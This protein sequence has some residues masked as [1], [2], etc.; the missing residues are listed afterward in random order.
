MSAPD[1]GSPSSRRRWLVPLLV[2]SVAVNLVIVGA[3]FSEQ[4]WPDHG[5]RKGSHRSADLMPRSF[6]GA[7]DDVRREELVEVFR[8]RK[9]EWREE[10]RAL[11]DAA[12]AYANALEREPFEAQPAL[13]AIEDHTARSHQLVDLGAA[14]A[15]DLVGALSPEERRAL[16]KAIRDRLE[17]ERQRRERRER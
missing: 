10:R 11:R 14:V 5:E 3:A 8:A 12:A 9:T 16:A 7:L 2:A 6:F 4:F 1:S 13:S 15:A 17:Q